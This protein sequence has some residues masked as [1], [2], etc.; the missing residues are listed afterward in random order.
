M[1]GSI[2][3]DPCEVVH[4]HLSM[5]AVL[6]LSGALLPCFLGEPVLLSELWSGVLVALSGSRVDVGV[7][8]KERVRVRVRVV[9]TVRIDEGDDVE[10]GV[11]AGLKEPV[12]EREPDALGVIVSEAL[13]V[14][15]ADRDAELVRDCECVPLSLGVTV[16]D[17]LAVDDG[18]GVAL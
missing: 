3:I 4:C 10:E 13:L 9:D 5:L 18:D 12:V 17:E 2:T 7:W 14:S 8:L 6:L 11:D 1:L 16:P 15:E